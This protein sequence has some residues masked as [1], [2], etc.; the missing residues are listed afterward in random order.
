MSFASSLGSCL[1]DLPCTVCILYLLR[2]KKFL[3]L[4]RLGLLESAVILLGVASFVNIIFTCL[5]RNPNHY[6]TQ[7]KKNLWAVIQIASK[8]YL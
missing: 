1:L 2:A 3:A 8:V 5:V 4:K 7:F 6:D